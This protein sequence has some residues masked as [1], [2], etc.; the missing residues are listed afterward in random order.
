MIQPHIFAGIDVPVW[1][2]PE[3]VASLIAARAY[4]EGTP[5]DCRIPVHRDQKFRTT[6]P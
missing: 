2:G 4:K 3:M 5:R 1:R 6:V